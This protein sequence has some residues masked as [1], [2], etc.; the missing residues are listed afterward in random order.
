MKRST[1]ATADPYVRRHLRVGW[2]ALFGF[3]L[4]GLLLDTLHG[5]KIPWYLSV[6]T[7]TR[8]LMWTLAHAHGTLLGLVNLALAATSRRMESRSPRFEALASSA[9]VASTILIPAGFVLG[10][11]FLHGGDPG[12]GSLL[13]PAGAVL[14]LFALFVIARR[15]P[16]DEEE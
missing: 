16:K 1:E 9:L 6:A 4:L 15:G 12:M 10:G 8:R 3:T 11:I 14:L 13:V 5:F 2:W 7:E